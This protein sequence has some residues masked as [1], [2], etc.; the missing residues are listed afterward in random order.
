MGGG[1]PLVVGT[2]GALA[3]YVLI[4]RGLGTEDLGL[5]RVSRLVVFPRGPQSD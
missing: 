2:C 1:F 3:V 5:G 4:A